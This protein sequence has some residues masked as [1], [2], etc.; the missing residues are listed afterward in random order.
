MSLLH[1][2]H[3]LMAMLP[4]AAGAVCLRALQATDLDAFAAYRGPIGIA[5]TLG[6]ALVGDIGLLREGQANVQIGIT[7]A[8][9]AQ[10]AR[11]RPGARWR[12]CWPSCTG[13]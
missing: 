9:A 8:R 5:H 7:L 11:A 2:P 12:H 6:D 10:R 13:L 1:E 3:P 4:L